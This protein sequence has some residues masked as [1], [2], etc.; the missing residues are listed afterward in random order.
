MKPRC[1]PGAAGLAETPR[2]AATHPRAGLEEGRRA[3]GP[4]G[5][6]GHGPWLLGWLCPSLFADRGRDADLPGSVST[7]I[8]Y[9]AG[10]VLSW[11]PLGLMF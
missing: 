11:F 10:S 4:W 3:A 7:S 1:L 5:R 2:L 8:R 9:E 6:L